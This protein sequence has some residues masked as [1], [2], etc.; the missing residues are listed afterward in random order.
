MK[1]QSINL[2]LTTLLIGSTS[3]C[4]PTRDSYTISLPKHIDLESSGQ[5]NVNLV[6]SNI[7]ENDTINIKFDNSFVLKDKHGKSDINGTLTNCD[8]SFTS[9]DTE[10]KTVYY[11]IN[12]ISAGDWQGAI[13]ASINMD[14]FEEETSSS[15][16]INGQ[17]INS[18]LK[19]LN[20]TT[21]TFSHDNYNGN[22]L[23]DLSSESDGSI[24]IYM[25]GTNC[26]ITNKNNKPIIANAD[27]SHIFDGLSVNSISN[28]NY[29][30]MS[31]CNDL[32]YAFS[33]LSNCISLDLSNLDTSN[34]SNMS[35]IFTKSF[36]LET[37]NLTGWNTSNVTNMES[38][39]DMD[40]T[41]NISS[42]QNIIGIENFDV[43]KV[44]TLSYAFCECRYLSADNDFS[45]WTPSSLTNL[46]YAF[47]NTKSLD[48]RDF[49]NWGKYFNISARKM[50]QCFGGD[51][52]HYLDQDY[53]P[54][55]Y[56]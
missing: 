35:Y 7:S 56:K 45:L 8:I 40:S 31:T 32:S 30:D 47:Y 12:D 42:L 33:N 39:F 11:E 27:M 28:I 10:T 1:I 18:I 43:S 20:P 29:V 26:I 21:V 9:S 53:R 51:A 14:L 55:W 54:S 25:E 48:L 19:A 44:T 15:T 36:A 2:F 5:F 50:K 13:N 49:E 24:I 23:Y 41:S 22:Y 37:V 38:M 46:T 17:N 34:I 3:L 6:E 4:P 16:L 52:G